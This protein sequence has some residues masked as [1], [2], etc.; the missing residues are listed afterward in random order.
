MRISKNE[1]G[2]QEWLKEKLSVAGGTRISSIV[3]PK[4]LTLSKSSKDLILK[5]IDEDIT[6]ISADGNFTSEAM[7]RGNEL[8][9]LARKKYEEITGCK[10]LQFGLCISDENKRHGLS[11]DGFSKDFKG[12]QEIKCPGAVKHLKY[13]NNEDYPEVTIYNDYKPQCINYFLVNKNLEWLDTVS[14]RPEFYPN[15]IH[16]ERI[17]RK[18]ILE[19]IAKVGKAVKEFFELFDKFYNQYTF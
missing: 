8:E 17:Y 13:I 6:G 1:Q 10:S 19:D 12:A 16:I 3:T 4:N 9:P 7:E 5:M 11:P 2:S 15:P 14:F 18:D